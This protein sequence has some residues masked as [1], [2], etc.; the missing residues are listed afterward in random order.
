MLLNVLYLRIKK[1]IWHIKRQHNDVFKHINCIPQRLILLCVSHSAMWLIWVKNPCPSLCG[2]ELCTMFMTL[3]MSFGSGDAVSVQ[4]FMTLFVSFVSGDVLSVQVFMTLFVI[5]VRRCR[6]STWH[7][8]CRLCQAMSCQYECSWHCLQVSFVICVRRCLVSTGVHDIVCVVCVRRCRVSTSVHDIVCVVCVRRCR[9]SMSVHDIVCSFVSGDVI[10][11]VVCVSMSVR[12]SWHCLCRLCQAMSCQYE[13]LTL[14]VSLSQAMSCQYGCSWCCLSQAMSCQYGCS[15]C[16]L[17]QVMSCLCCLCQ[18][19]S[20]QYECSWHCLCCLCQAMS[21]Q[22]ECSWCC[23]SQTM[24][25]QYGC[26]WH[27][28]CCLCQAMSCQYECSWHCLC[29]LG[30]A[31][32][33]FMTLFVLFVSG[34]VMSVWGQ[35]ASDPPIAS[36]PESRWPQSFV[37]LQGHPLLTSRSSEQRPNSLTVARPLE[38]V[39]YMFHL[40]VRWWTTANRYS[41]MCGNRLN[42]C[43]LGIVDWFYVHYGCDIDGNVGH[44]QVSCQNGMSQKCRHG[45]I[46]ICIFSTFLRKMYELCKSQ[47]LLYTCRELSNP[48]SWGL[49]RYENSST[50]NCRGDTASFGFKKKLN[51]IIRIFPW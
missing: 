13:C 19:M 39:L 43:G 27:C 49:C 41:T 31:V 11:C 21:C 48:A 24:S 5:C 50:R 46:E 3:F 22:Y 35:A 34:D 23:L 4:V 33:V 47:V 30:Q 8:L 7:C 16:C 15:W 12:C 51:C 44:V 42:D 6:V 37:S 2:N 40:L 14:F 9:V 45:W 26:S 25:C 17:S 38:A 32:R 36:V 29:C 10:V 18:A 1:E 20:C 28:L